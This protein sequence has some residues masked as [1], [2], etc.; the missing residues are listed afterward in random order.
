M[1]SDREKRHNT[2]NCMQ[3]AKQSRDVYYM[4]DLAS[5]ITT[6][7]VLLYVIAGR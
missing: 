2:E 4:I 7:L 6:V 1:K 5:I 3:N